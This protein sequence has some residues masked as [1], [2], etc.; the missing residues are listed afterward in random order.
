MNVGGASLPLI[1]DLL[2]CCLYI[3]VKENIICR[4]F[5]FFL[6]FMESLLYQE[7]NASL[8]ISNKCKAVVTAATACV[9]DGDDVMLQTSHHFKS[10]FLEVLQ[11]SF[12]LFFPK[13]LPFKSIFY[14]F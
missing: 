11:Q 6:L 12:N 1:Y 5:R 2:L 4:T 9:L 14:I 13:V 3:D 10:E 7:P 8:M